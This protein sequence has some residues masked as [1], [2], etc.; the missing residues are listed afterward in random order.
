MD[1]E[2]TNITI[3]AW[4]SMS[5][6]R[7]SHRQKLLENFK[8]CKRTTMHIGLFLLCSSEEFSKKVALRT[9]LNAVSICRV[10]GVEKRVPVMM[11]LYDEDIR[12]SKIS[13]V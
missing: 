13:G 3:L 4:N 9:K 8:Q 2:K 11:F 7:F 10:L 5:L 1:I 12:Q 6:F